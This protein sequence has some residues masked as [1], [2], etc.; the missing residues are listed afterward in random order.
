MVLTCGRADHQLK[1]AYHD[2]CAQMRGPLATSM[3]EEVGYQV[4]CWR[5]LVQASL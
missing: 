4:I 5:S 1:W 3:D 2:G